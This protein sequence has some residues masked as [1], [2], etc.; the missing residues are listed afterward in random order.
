MSKKVEKPSVLY[1][2]IK[3][4]LFPTVINKALM[5]YFGLNY[6]ESPGEGYGYGLLFTIFIL[7]FL[8]GRFI[9]KYRNIEDP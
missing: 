5:L 4:F 7:L 9:W 3:A 8:M 6:S 2:F 1:D